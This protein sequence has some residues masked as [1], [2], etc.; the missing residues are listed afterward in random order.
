[1]S[2]KQNVKIR[3]NT[4][5]REDDP[6]TKE[7]RVIVEGKENFCNHVTINCPSQTSKD[8][9]E[10]IGPKWHIS[11]RAAKIDYLT[12]PDHSFPDNFFREIIIS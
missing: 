11:C 10:G 8:L 1:M 4:N 12:D 5:F 2:V 3:F 6:S 9:I 7:W